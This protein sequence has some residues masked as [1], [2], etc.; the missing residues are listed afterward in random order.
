MNPSNYHI[1]ETRNLFPVKCN[2]FGVKYTGRSLILEFWV[3]FVTVITLC[4]SMVL[5][6]SWYTK[7]HHSDSGDRGVEHGGADDLRLRDLYCCC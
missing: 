2:S 3:T 7:S 1:K 5:L 4:M 6:G